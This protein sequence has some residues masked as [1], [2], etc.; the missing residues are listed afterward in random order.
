[1]TEPV[2]YRASE[3]KRDRWL[4]FNQKPTMNVYEVIEP[5][6]TAEQL[7]PRV[8]MT[9][10]EFDEW[11]FLYEDTVELSLTA[12]RV[13]N[14]IL[15]STHN[16]GGKYVEL[17]KRVYQCNDSMSVSKNQAELVNLFINY[18]PDNPEETIEIAPDMKW[19]V[20]TKNT[21]SDY[22]FLKIE[23]ENK[24]VYNKSL[25]IYATHFETQ[26]Q[27]ESWVNPLTKAVQLPVE[28]E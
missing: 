22:R 8:K 26:S 16:I 2:A 4:L 27:A 24:S 5:L 19:F 11:K 7:Q 14:E 18:S 28:G 6:Y 12:Y 1:M 25:K 13:L 10:T 23:F 3:R 9:K 15:N 20:E 21:T 17:S